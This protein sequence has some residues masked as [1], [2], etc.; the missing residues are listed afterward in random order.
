MKLGITSLSR[1]NDEVAI[2]FCDICDFDKIIAKEN[3]NI[4]KI[5]DY[6]F[7]EFDGF[8]LQNGVQKIEVCLFPLFILVF[9]LDGG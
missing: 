8:C 9:F 3:T 1:P 5:L 2:L 7:R 6:L 4:V